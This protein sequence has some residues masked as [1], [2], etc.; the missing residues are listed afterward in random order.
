MFQR[1]L[2][3]LCV[4]VA[5]APGA[6]LGETPVAREARELR[7]VTA[8]EVLA[9]VREPGARAVLVNVWATWCAPCVEEMPYLARLKREYGP[10]GLRLI[11]VSADFEEQ[12]A[13]AAAFLDRQEV[14]AVS[15]IKREKD[16][17][18]IDAIHPPWSGA[19]PASLLYDE[20]GRLHFF[21][22]GAATYEDLESRILEI[23]D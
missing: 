22:E 19:L 10:R 21:W 2:I 16:E 11:V 15:L 23:L 1:D 18:F 12:A 14:D 17:T 8:A 9:A 6:V 3:L 13:A 4:L 20:E 7:A 5:M